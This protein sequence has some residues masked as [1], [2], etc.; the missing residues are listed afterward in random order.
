MDQCMESLVV[1]AWRNMS[2]KKERKGLTSREE[3]KQLRMLVDEL[4][5][6]AAWELPFHVPALQDRAIELRRLRAIST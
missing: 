3:L 5:V 6:L 4:S 1:K 2:E